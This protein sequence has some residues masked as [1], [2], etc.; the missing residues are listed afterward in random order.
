MTRDYCNICGEQIREREEDLDQKELYEKHKKYFE[1]H[2]EGRID[3]EYNR[4]VVNQKG[5]LLYFRTD[6]NIH[7]CDKCHARLE[8]AVWKELKQMLQENEGR[9]RSILMVFPNFSFKP[10]V[11][12][13]ATSFGEMPVANG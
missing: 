7:F 2:S 11:E 8:K 13:T 3:F 12:V 5:E 10:E 1:A 9:R 6:Y 4:P